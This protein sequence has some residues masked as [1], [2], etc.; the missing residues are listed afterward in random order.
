MGLTYT[1]QEAMELQRE[2]EALRAGVPQR[3]I[4]LSRLCGI[5]AMDVHTFREFSGKGFLIVVRCPKVSARAWHGL[6]PPKP[7]SIKDKSGS[8]GVAV[9]EPGKMLVSDYDLMSIWHQS[10]SGWRKVFASAANGAPRGKYSAEATAIIKELNRS[11]VSRIQHGCQDNYCSPHNPGVKMA[12]HFATFCHGV[13]E[14][15][16]NP[17]ACKA[18]YE[19][20]R[21]V[22]LY[23]QTGVYLFD[24]ARQGL[25]QQ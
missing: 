9:K 11:L 4:D 23:G 17:A 25:A 1:I 7:I 13:G 22:W 20:K 6:I 15:S 19:R 18:F 2:T 3:D 21:L 16:A 24:V 8:S 5:D 14:Y 12:D 10:G